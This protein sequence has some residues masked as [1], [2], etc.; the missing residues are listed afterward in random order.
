[1]STAFIPEPEL[2]DVTDGET[3]T[4]NV[5][6]YLSFWGCDPCYD[7]PPRNRGDGY[8]FYNYGP[9]KDITEYLQNRLL[10]ALARQ[11]KDNTLTDLDRKNFE[12]IIAHVKDRLERKK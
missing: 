6:Q 12:S 4:V 2:T 3:V 8:I 10:P 7:H 11:L 5:A 9:E 1:M